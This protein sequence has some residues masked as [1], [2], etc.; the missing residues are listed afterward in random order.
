MVSGLPACHQGSLSRGPAISEANLHAPKA[1]TILLSSRPD[2]DWSGHP[3]PAP[4]IERLATRQRKHV[5]P[6]G[7]LRREPELPQHEEI[8]IKAPLAEHEFDAAPVSPT[9]MRSRHKR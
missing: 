5:D 2:E 8:E 1:A 6:N 7:R 4:S 9:Q 3:P